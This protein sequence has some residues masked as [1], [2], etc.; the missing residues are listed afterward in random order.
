MT[1]KALVQKELNR[2]K[3]VKKYAEKRKELKAKMSRKSS[4]EER[5]EAMLAFTELPRNSAKIRLHN[6]CAITGRPKGY[7][8]KF[9]LSRIKFRKLAS[10][11]QLPGVKKSSW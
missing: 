11:G 2:E 6:R 10:L 9:G 5:V 8:G 4:P 7:I 1:R 3:L